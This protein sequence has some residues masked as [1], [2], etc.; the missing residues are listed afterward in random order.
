MA[1]TLSARASIGRDVVRLG[2]SGPSPHAWTVW[3]SARDRVVPGFPTEVVLQVKASRVNYRH[4]GIPSR[5][6]STADIVCEV[7]R[8]GI[9]ATVSDATSGAGYTTRE[10]PLAASHLDLP[11][12]PGLRAESGAHRDLY[13]RCWDGQPL[14]NDDFVLSADEKTSIKRASARIRGRRRARDSRCASD[15]NTTWWR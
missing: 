8:H 2:A 9:V 11:A 14:T 13:A 1:I 3:W 12:R 6:L 7:Q 10:P 4:L 5:R 15:T